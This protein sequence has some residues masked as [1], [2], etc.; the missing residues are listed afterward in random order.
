MKH[1]ILLAA[2]SLVVCSVS[3]QT[4]TTA[5]ATDSVPPAKNT[6]TVG[7]SYAN[8]ANYYGQKTAEPLPYIAVAATYKLKGGLYFSG[9]AYR[10]FKDTANTVSAGSV[11]IGYAFNLS[12]RWSADISYNHSFYPKYSPFL[13]ASNPDNASATLAYDNWLNTKLTIDYAF[14]NTNDGFATLGTG[15]EIRLGSFSTK[16]LITFSPSVDVV[17]GTQHFYQTY[18]TEKHIR[19][20][21]VAAV[22]GP[23]FGQPSGG[24]TSTSKTV[25]TTEFAV[26]SYN[27][28][29]PLAYNR[30]HYMLELAY[31]L[32]VLSNK[33]QSN[34]GKANSF[35]SAS[36]YYQ[37]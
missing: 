12:K 9:L 4:D 23:I 2:M 16:D 7:T 26:L 24:N 29:C 34:P 30:T 32:S 8:T 19:D 14:G 36:F 13:Q 11:G 10:L 5:A 17:A 22:L 1:I 28:K 33:A 27:L 6:F 31:Q 35:F 15:K 18:L 37:F 3:A 25:V 20:S 21:I